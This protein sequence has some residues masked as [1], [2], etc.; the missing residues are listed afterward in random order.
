MDNT[1]NRDTIDFMKPENRF[2]ATPMDLF[3]QGLR[4]QNWEAIA[5]A[6]LMLTGEK[7]EA[8]KH[9]D[10]DIFVPSE[11]EQQVLLQPNT[12][13]PIQVMPEPIP[14]RKRGRPRKNPVVV[15]PTPIVP[16]PS[17]ISGVPTDCVAPAMDPSKRKNFTKATRHDCRPRENTWRDDKTES[18]EEIVENRNVPTSILETQRPPVPMIKVR[19][20]GCGTIDIVD[21]GQVP[22]G[23]KLTPKYRMRYL[24]NSCCV[25]A[26]SSIDMENDIGD[27]PL[28]EEELVNGT[29]IG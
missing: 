22:Y 23:L 15:K 21:P 12:P 18:A 2:R 27:E 26:K 13:E 10:V 20:S 4:T 28:F 7:I 24:C 9:N 8:H 5:A 6:Y 1:A 19:C 17:L 11:K 16:V 25:G 3:K 14:K 29:T